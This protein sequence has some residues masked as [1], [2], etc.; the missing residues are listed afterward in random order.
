[1]WYVDGTFK[2]RPLLFAQLYVVHYEYHDHVLPGVVVLMESKSEEAYHAVFTA[3]SL[4][5]PEEHRHGPDHF[6]ID[7]ELAA[8]NAFKRVFVAAT[9][10]FCFF[11]FAQSMW[12][13]LQS[14]GASA[15]YM[16]DDNTVLREQFHAILSLCYVPPCDVPLAFDILANGCEEELDEVCDHI[17]DY[18]V[19]GRSRGRGRQRPRYAIEK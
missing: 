13:K 1:M 19:R 9:E 11:H 8:S 5:M 17:E 16:Q 15:A 7:F 6:S 18:Y 3:M 4:L 12:R 2:Y 10:Q 14:S